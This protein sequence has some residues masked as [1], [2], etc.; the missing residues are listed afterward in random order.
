MKKLVALLLAVMMLSAM[1]LAEAPAVVEGIDF[2]GRTVKIFTWY[3]MSRKAEPTQEE[4][5]LYDYQDWLMETYNVKVEYEVPYDWATSI[6][7]LSEFVQNPENKNNL[8]IFTMPMDFIGP[9]MKNELI[10]AWNDLVDLSAEKWNQGTLEFMTTK[11]QTLGVYSGASEPRECVFFNVQALRDANIDIDAEIYDKQL[12]GEW[13]WDYM[14]ELFAKIQKDVDGDGV[15]D[16]WA[17][18]GNGDDMAMAAIASNGASFYK[19]VDGKLVVNI[20]TEEFIEAIAYAKTIRDNYFRRAQ[21]DAEG[22]T[23]SWDYYKV[24][25]VQ[26]EGVFRFGQTWEGFNGN[27]AMNVDGFEWGCVAFPTGPKAE[28]GAYKNI[29]N[30]NITCIPKLYTEEENKLLG[31]LFDQWTNPVPGYEDDTEGWIG[32]KYDYTDERAVEE[33]YA[34]LRSAEYTTRDY[35]IFTGDKNSTVCPDM[36]WPIDSMDAAALVE[37]VLP[38]FQARADDFNK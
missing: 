3:D 38:V 31:F 19:L 9:A 10:I 11:G 12:N 7:Y 6:D 30:D 18:T 4:Q 34:M 24:G 2:G 32:N 15:I 35:Y 22:N 20:D 1:A 27:E 29:V 25:F 17:S 21:T 28:A 33:T 37:S 14:L 36:L 13:T 8:A 16:V 23:E 26:G 5:D